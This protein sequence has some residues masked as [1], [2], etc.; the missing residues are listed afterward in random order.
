MRTLLLLAVL[1]AP[2]CAADLAF[3]M[4]RVA[5]ANSLFE[6]MPNVLERTQR[7]PLLE[8]TGR[9]TGEQM[10]GAG[11]SLGIDSSTIGLGVGGWFDFYFT[12][13]IAIEANARIGYGILGRRYHDGGTGLIA[14]FGLGAKF[15]MDFEEWEFTEWCRPF[16]VLSP[17]GFAFLAGD[18]AAEDNGDDVRTKYSDILFQVHGGVGCDFFLTDLIGV[19]L[20][21]YMYGTIGG[22]KQTSADVETRT[23][24][25]VG[26]FFEYARLSLRF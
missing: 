17:I 5:R 13:W 21:L 1:S 20:G 15:V 26:V 23:R 11:V 4:P 3:E 16:A 8:G 22:R 19:G 7:A 10:F 14:T 25:Q 24:G 12:P 6:G 18:E 9:A 2:L